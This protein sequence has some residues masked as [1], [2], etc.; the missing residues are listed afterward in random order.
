MK[1]NQIINSLSEISRK[2]PDETDLIQIEGI[3][4]P[5]GVM[6]AA[7]TAEGICLLEFEDYRMLNNELNYL[8]KKYNAGFQIGRNRHINMLESQLQEYFIGERKVFEITMQIPGTDFQQSVWQ[9]L[10]S[11]PYGST[12]SYKEQAVKLGRPGA[13]R[14][15]A[16]ANGMNRIAILVHCHRIIGSDGSLTGYSGGLARKKWLLEHEKRFR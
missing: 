2:N 8:Q 3:S 10:K 14:A 5:L 9:L 13:V 15:V 7:S 6:Y 16:S 1:L 12:S 4:T 11:I